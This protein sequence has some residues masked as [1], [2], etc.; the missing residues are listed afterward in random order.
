M[1]IKGDCTIK[2][3]YFSGAVLEVILTWTHPDLITL[4]WLT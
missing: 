3:L 1:A 4:R 2:K